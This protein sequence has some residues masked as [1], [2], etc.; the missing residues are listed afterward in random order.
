MATERRWSRQERDARIANRFERAQGGQVTGI[1]L[2]PPHPV[3][4]Y[5]QSHLQEAFIEGRERG[6]RGY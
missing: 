6:R 4:G 5:T 3:V 1:S 2:S